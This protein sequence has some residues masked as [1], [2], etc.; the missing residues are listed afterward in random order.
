MDIFSD[1]KF[2]EKLNAHLAAG[3]VIAF[4]TDTVWGLGALPTPMGADALYETKQR[5]AQKYFPIMSDTIEH[6]APHMRDWSPRA[7]ELAAKYWPGALTIKYGED[8]P[9]YGGLRIPDAPIFQKLCSVI[10][11]HCLATTSANVSGQPILTSAD[12]IRKT[13]PDVIVIDGELPPATGVASTVIRVTGN[14]V[15]ILRQGAIV[16]E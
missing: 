14:D 16:I 4:P 11:G 15:E 10:D 2:I 3:G 7:R 9:T 6:L 13:F 12:E 1:K 5:P 8:T